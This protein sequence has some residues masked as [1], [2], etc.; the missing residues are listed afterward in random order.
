M[1]QRPLFIVESEAKAKMLEQLAGEG[2]SCFL[3]SSLPV[4][5]EVLSSPG[6]APP[7]N[8]EEAY[9]FFL[10]KSEENLAALF[11]KSAE[12]Q[13]YLA[14]DGD[15]KGRHWAWL[16][17]NYLKVHHPVVKC[18]VLRPGGLTPVE[19]SFALEQADKGKTATSDSILIRSLFSDHLSGHL[20]R[21][22]GTRNG[23]NKL[24][25]HFNSLTILFLIMSRD[26]ENQ[27]YSPLLQ[28]H[29]SA[30]LDVAGRELWAE[31]KRCAGE[32]ATGLANEE[33][34]RTLEEKVLAAGLTVTGIEKKKLHLPPPAPYLLAELLQEFHAVHQISPKTILQALRRFYHGVSSGETRKGLISWYLPGNGELSDDTLD[35]IDAQVVERFGEK[36][37]SGKVPYVADGAIL[38]L[39]PEITAADLQDVLSKQEQLLYELIRLRTLASRMR[40][41]VGQSIVCTLQCEDYVFEVSDRQIEQQG[42]LAAGAQKEEFPLDKSP[43]RQVQEGQVL[44]VARVRCEHKSLY[45]PEPYTFEALFADL[46]NFSIT[47]DDTLVLLLQFMGEA[48]YIDLDDKG[49]LTPLANA[50]KVVN[51]FNRVFPSMQGLNLS[52]YLEQTREEVASSRKSLDFALKQV[53]QALR[54]HGKSLISSSVSAA[55]LSTLQRKRQRRV[56]SNVIKTPEAIVGGKPA[57]EVAASQPLPSIREEAASLSMAEEGVKKEDSPPRE[58]A[59][60]DLPPAVESLEAPVAAEEPPEAEKKE[61]LL[62]DRHAVKA[63][64]KEM[65]DASLQQGSE[66]ETF[67]GPSSVPA[68][69]PSEAETDITGDAAPESALFGEQWQPA[70]KPAAAEPAMPLPRATA[71]AAEEKAKSRACSVCGRPMVLGHDQYGQFYICTGFPACRYAEPEKSE[72]REQMPCPVC[73]KGIVHV[74]MTPT[75][76]TLFVCSE[77]DCEFMAWAKPHPIVC[78]SCGSPFLV[79]KKLLSGEMELRCPRAGCNFR[80]PL[81]SAG[82]N[83]A[84]VRP[85]ASAERKKKVRIRR[86][87]GASVAASGKKRVVRVVR[88]RK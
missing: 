22:I 83:A 42:F 59:V 47:V 51:V 55:T 65:R 44:A 29:A 6:D 84:D 48:G 39:W 14:L 32:S 85:A 68:V 86:V 77:M 46:A 30:R 61:K 56:S 49:S 40:P 11:E 87:A 45:P 57:A 54:I 41:A 74:K 10:N 13:I 12:R 20:Q 35:I 1:T 66:G 5:V 37:L 76:K 18:Q 16:L 3:L 72:A 24:P 50:H 88:R 28:W 78:P 62:E 71:L 21:L 25:L 33:Q 4:R 53:D 8:N 52:A 23:P 58:K 19:F 7:A 80:Q 43:L 63:G 31:F 15:S 60:P 67:G 36:A 75:G 17:Q 27:M 2:A 81:S 82:E 64:E 9:A 69:G 38:A 26:E 79:E 73:A 70:A 34:G